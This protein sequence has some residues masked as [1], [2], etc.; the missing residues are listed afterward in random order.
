MK[1]YKKKEGKKCKNSSI[2]NFDK[3]FHRHQLCDPIFKRKIK[4]Q[5]SNKNM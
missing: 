2:F 5:N 4:C 3:S 1:R